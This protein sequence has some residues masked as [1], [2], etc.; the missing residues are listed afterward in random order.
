MKDT[1]KGKKRQTTNWEKKFI[2]L[3]GNKVLI[4]RI[5]N[6]TVNSK[7]TAQV[8]NGPKICTETSPKKVYCK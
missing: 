3:A 8:K 7:K 4:F 6:S 1:V 2:H 5:N